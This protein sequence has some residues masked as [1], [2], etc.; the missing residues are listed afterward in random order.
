MEASRKSSQSTFSAVASRS[1]AKTSPSPARE[2]GSTDRARVFG[3]N[4]HDSLASFDPATSSWR[5]SQLSLLGGLDEFSGTWPRSGMTRNGTA[6]RLQPLAPLTGGTA[7]GLLPTPTAVDHKQ[8]NSPAARARKS[9]SLGTVAHWPTPNA[10]DGSHGGAQD[11]EKRKAQGHAVGL[12]DAVYQG[13]GNGQLNPTW[14]E[15][16]MGFPLGWTDLEASETPSSPRSQSG[17]E[18]A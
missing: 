1:C 8:H 18:A 10:R 13:K 15:W 9:P 11:P 5:T 7:S 4:T 17:S 14:V 2:Q 6:Y 3:P 16:L 12:D